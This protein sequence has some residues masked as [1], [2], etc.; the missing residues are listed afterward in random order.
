MNSIQSI[1]TSLGENPTIEIMTLVDESDALIASYPVG[2]LNSELDDE[3][4]YFSD[5]IH[6]TEKIEIVSNSSGNSFYMLDIKLSAA[7]ERAVST[8]IQRQ[9]MYVYLAMQLVMIIGI[10]MIFLQTY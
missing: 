2:Q 9:I 10:I 1:F 8:L 3:N 7:Y 5:G 6:H 4:T